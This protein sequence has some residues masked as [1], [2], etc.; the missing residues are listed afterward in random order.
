MTSY[1]LIKK[2]DFNLKIHTKL[3]IQ[4]RSIRFGGCCDP[5]DMLI[6]ARGGRQGRDKLAYNDAII[7]ILH[8]NN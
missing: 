4:G 7:H 5:N 1:F 2:Y 3:L 6:V 8:S